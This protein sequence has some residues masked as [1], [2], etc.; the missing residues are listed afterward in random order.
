MQTK[1]SIILNPNLNFQTYIFFTIIITDF[2]NF[3]IVFTDH[4]I[5]LHIQIFCIRRLNHHIVGTE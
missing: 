5:T 1:Y 4:F 3:Q 2:N